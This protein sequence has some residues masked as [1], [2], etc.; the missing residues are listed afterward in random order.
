VR[1]IPASFSSTI[2]LSEHFGNVPLEVLRKEKAL[3]TFRKQTTKYEK[4]QLN[5]AV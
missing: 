3:T 5:A 4:C 1:F 2:Q